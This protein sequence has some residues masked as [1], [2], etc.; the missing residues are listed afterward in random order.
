MLEP[1]AAFLG[2]DQATEVRGHEG[3]VDR[4]GDPDFVLPLVAADLFRVDGDA[5]EIRPMGGGAEQAEDQL[6]GGID[7]QL[8]GGRPRGMRQG[9]P[10]SCCRC[11]CRLC[12]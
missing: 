2:V 9:L 12:D 5:V 1:D 3:A 8:M 11:Y 7:H 4:K 10:S 6:C